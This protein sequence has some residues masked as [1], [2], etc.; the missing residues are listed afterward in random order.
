MQ[1]NSSD[2]QIEIES[3]SDRTPKKSLR[4]QSIMSNISLLH[5]QEKDLQGLTKERATSSSGVVS[6]RS[7]AKLSYHESVN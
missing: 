4:S 6:D 7:Q 3:I 1:D 5:K 2:E